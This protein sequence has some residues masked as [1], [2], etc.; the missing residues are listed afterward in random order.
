MYTAILAG[1]VFF[2]RLTLCPNFSR[3]FS[4]VLL[5]S[6]LTSLYFLSF[7]WLPFVK[8]FCDWLVQIVSGSFWG[9][10]MLGFSPSGLE[11]M[12]R[13]RISCYMHFLS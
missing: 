11:F 6:L 8:A 4:R 13:L 2:R 10:L 1:R 3:I 12:F 5:Q 7:D 9:L